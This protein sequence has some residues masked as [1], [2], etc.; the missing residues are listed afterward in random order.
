MILTVYRSKECELLGISCKITFQRMFVG[1]TR[2][3]RGAKR[4][5]HPFL[6]RSRLKDRIW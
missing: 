4:V 1:S 5:F 2:A 6:I 3:F